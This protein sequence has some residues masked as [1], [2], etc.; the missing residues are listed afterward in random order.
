MFIYKP[1]CNCSVKLSIRSPFPISL[2]EQVQLQIGEK[3]L[4]KFEYSEDTIK[5][6]TKLSTLSPLKLLIKK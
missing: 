3:I 2:E 4:K 6:E 1:V 5:I